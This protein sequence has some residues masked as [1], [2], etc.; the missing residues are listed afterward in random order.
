MALNISIHAPRAGG[1]VD[2][3]G[4]SADYILFQSTP[5]VRGATDNGQRNATARHNFNPRPSCGGR[6]VVDKVP[7]YTEII[8]IH[9]PRAGG[10][11][12]PRYHNGKGVEISIHAPRAGGDS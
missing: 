7:C 8:S 5:P 3:F 11:F 4:V 12:I 2:Y 1:D 10:D 6:R 9:A